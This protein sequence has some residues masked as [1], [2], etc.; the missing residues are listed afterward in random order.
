M[1]MSNRGQRS[2]AAEPAN[3]TRIGGPV[4][5]ASATLRVF[6]DTLDPDVVTGLLKH[7]PSFSY[8]VGDQVSPRVAAHRRQ[9]MW[10]LES[11]LPRTA[12]LSAQV[13]TLLSQV[14]DDLSVWEEITGRHTADVYCGLDI[15]LPNCGEE[16]TAVALAALA[17]RKLSL[18]FDFYGLSDEEDSQAR[19]S[20]Q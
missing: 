14:S 17:A 9:G 19:S 15:R 2:E 5:A 16:L 10:G 12:A 20:G 7:S 4:L 11:A 6:G 3:A 1:G 13:L 18:Q 8:R